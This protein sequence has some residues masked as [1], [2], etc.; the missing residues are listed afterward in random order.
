MKVKEIMTSDVVGVARNA[1]IEEVAHI[2][3]DK[4]ITSVPV[5]DENNCVVG[6]VSEKDLIYKDVNP[7]APATVEYLGG[8]IFLDG[9]DEYQTELRKLT[10]TQVEEMMS[11][12]VVTI[13]EEDNVNEAARIL[14]HEGISSVPVLKNDKLV[15]IVSCSDIIKTLIQ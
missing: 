2:M 3:V 5:V 12:D 1:T 10:A 7:T 11:K 9:V 14:A 4:R 15:G 8:I 6:I 13:Q